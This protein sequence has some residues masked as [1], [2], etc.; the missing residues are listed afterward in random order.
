MRSGTPRSF[1]LVAQQAERTAVNREV[2]GSN[3]DEVA[4]VFDFFQIFVCYYRANILIHRLEKM[5]REACV[6]DGCASRPIYLFEVSG[7]KKP[8]PKQGARCCSKHT[9][10]LIDTYYNLTDCVYSKILH[11]N[12]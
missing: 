12:K 1:D 8:L 3:P 11:K 5:D 7:T 6:Y 2:F 10:F 9:D 4:F